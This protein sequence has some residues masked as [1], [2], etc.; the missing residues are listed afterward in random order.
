[1]HRSAKVC[2]LIAFANAPFVTAAQAA[3]D[4]IDFFERKIRPILVEHCLECHS[5]NTEIESGFSLDGKATVQKGGD[6]GAAINPDKPETSLFLVAISYDDAD[7]QMP[8]NGKLSEKDLSLLS[9]WVK[10]GA[11]M[12]EASAKTNGPRVVDFEK[13]R[14][15]WAFKPLN[16]VAIEVNG[17]DGSRIDAVINQRLREAEISGNH[18]A[19]RQTLIRRLSFALRG[20]PPTWEEVSAFVSSN[21]P[22]A[23]ERLVDRYLASPGY[24][25]KWARHWLDLA[26]YTDETASWLKRTDS[27]YRFR[28]WVVAAFND[29]LPYDDFI[30][31]QL[32]AD[33]LPNTQP[34]EFAALGFIGLSPTYWKEPRLDPDVIKVVVAEEWEERID[35]IGRTFLGMSLACARCHDHKFDP[36]TTKDYYSLASILANTR[37]IELPVLPPDDRKR[38]LG[39]MYQIEKLEQ[40]HELLKY[41]SLTATG[42]AKNEMTTRMADITTKIDDLKSNTAGFD[43]P[44]VNAVMDSAVM[45]RQF[46]TFFTALDFDPEANVE[47]NVHLRGNPSNSGDP[48]SKRYL[49]LFNP[50]KAAF[51][52]GSGRAE[53]AESLL[54]ESASL[55]ARVMVNRQWMHLMGTPIVDTPSDFGVQGAKPS[56][57]GLLDEMAGKLIASDWSLKA[58]HRAIVTS[59]AFRRAGDIVDDSYERDPSNR[60]YWRYAP[61]RLEVEAWRDAMLFVSGD[62]ET[63]LGGPAEE[64]TDEKNH[65][66][67]L[68]GRINRRDLSTV[69]KLHG[70][71]EATGHSPKREQTVSPLQQ[72]FV[73]N[74]DFVRK[75]SERVVDA[76][77]QVEETEHSIEKLF[78]TVFA[79]TVTHDELTASV[80]FIDGSRQAGSDLNEIWIQYVHALL[81][82]NEFAFVR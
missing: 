55:V 68:Y 56:N 70:F 36:V 24:G 49:E 17:K 32:A 30:R 23:Y 78:Q 52:V 37:L 25:E 3:D 66:R 61:L 10:M 65:R 64:L 43:A 27:A 1:M 33:F 4:G 31:Y 44:R 28:D 6:R 18:E 42:E 2:L 47:L 8:P 60:S 50:D 76:F 35:T 57:Q 82:T 22:D 39:S 63:R 73:L 14:E 9:Q 13:G 11:P 20:L 15:H 59:D 77:V 80:E 5:A 46:D 79:R 29:D 53:L 72:L 51:D 71:P 21:S 19:S 67:T 16:S 69:L 75:Q 48:V 41:K 58:L 54:S 12:P 74:S 40:E 26:R 81:M 34:N 62:L 7:L 45:V 38:V